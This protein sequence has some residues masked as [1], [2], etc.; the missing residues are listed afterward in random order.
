MALYIFWIE[1]ILAMLDGREH[2]VSPGLLICLCPEADS[3][4]FSEG[5]PAPTNDNLQLPS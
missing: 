1:M 4:P 3:R 5:I 2:P